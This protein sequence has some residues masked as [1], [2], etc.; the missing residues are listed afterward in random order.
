MREIELTNEEQ[1]MF[2]KFTGHSFVVVDDATDA[3]QVYLYAG[4][5][6]F[7]VNSYSDTEEEAIWMRAM[8]AKALC[9]VRA[10]P[11]D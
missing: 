9:T 2:D 6:Y 10:E 1:D 8:L 4:V 3:C 5:Q 11:V 7:Q